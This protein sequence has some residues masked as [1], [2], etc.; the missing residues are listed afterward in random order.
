MSGNG[1]ALGYVGGVGAA[2]YDVGG[3]VGGQPE[4]GET[5]L[6]FPFPRAVSFPAGL[7][8]SQGVVATAPEANAAFDLRRNAVSFGTMTFA[9]AAAIA[10][11]AAS[12][13]TTFAAGDVL[14]VV[15]P[16][17]RDAALADL[18]FSFAGTRS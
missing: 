1:W 8:G 17:P 12:T 3:S 9:A 4:A 10:T 15:A 7:P 6:R 14:T 2:P 11:F 16:T 13:E 18:G 5:I